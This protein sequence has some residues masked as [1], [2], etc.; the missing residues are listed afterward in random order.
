MIPDVNLPNVTSK[1]IRVTGTNQ[2]REVKAIDPLS[3]TMSPVRLREYLRIKMHHRLLETEFSNVTVRAGYDRNA[4]VSLQEKDGKLFNW[5]R[6]TLQLHGNNAELLC[7]PGADYVQHYSLI[8]AT[9]F[10]MSQTATKVLQSADPAIRTQNHLLE[11][12]SVPK[13]KPHLVVT[14]WGLEQ[15]AGTEDWKHGLGHAW[16]VASIEGRSV[17]FLGFKY[18]IW[19]D[20]AREVVT[21]LADQG[22]T[23]I[24]YVGKVGGLSPDLTPNSCLAT[25]ST[26]IVDGKVLEWDNLMSGISLPA[27]TRSGVHVTSPSTLLESRD[28]LASNSNHDFVDPEIGRMAESS[29]DNQVRFGYLHVVSN[30]LS[31]EFEEDL[32]NERIPNVIYARSKLLHGIQSVVSELSLKS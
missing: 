25:G 6:P 19:G 20:I 15:L 14:G 4:E 13:P 7:F 3:H 26:S 16:K 17:A 18:S 23:R 28:W 10:G 9:F 5:Q 21:R 8:L 24:L 32:S 29:I 27:Y 31:V 30:N 22:V 12:V 11:H 1:G 2:L